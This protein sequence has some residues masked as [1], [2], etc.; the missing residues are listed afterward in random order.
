[1]LS[2][3]YALY[4]L[5]AVQSGTP[6][7]QGPAGPQGEQGPI[8]LTGPAGPAGSGVGFIHWV[9]EAFGGGVVFHV[10]KDAL[11]EEHGLIVSLTDL[12]GLNIGV[13][14]GL[15]GTDVIDCESSWNGSSNTAAIIGAGAELESAAVLSYNYLGGG[16]D[17]WYLPAIDEIDLINQVKYNLNMSF[18]S[19]SGASSFDIGSGSYYWSSSEFNESSAWAF[20]FRDGDKNDYNAKTNGLFVRAVRAF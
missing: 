20:S 9:G 14:W 18:S 12:T 4:A 19:I 11:G 7:P 1:M 2:V 15:N 5:Y 16:Y 17:D 10:Y 6:G 8:G 13:T 3:P